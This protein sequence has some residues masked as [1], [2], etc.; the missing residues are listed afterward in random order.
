MK[1]LSLVPA[2]HLGFYGRIFPAAYVPPDALLD[3]TTDLRA[4]TRP[5][6]ELLAAVVSAAN[7]CF[8]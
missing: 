6:I 1:G 7:N 2:E 8:D 5:Q 3:F 4:L